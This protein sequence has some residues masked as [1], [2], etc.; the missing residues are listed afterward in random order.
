LDLVAAKLALA[1]NAT[2]SSIAGST[3]SRHVLPPGHLCQRQLQAGR[4]RP[5][6]Q[7]ARLADELRIELISSY[8]PQ[9]KGRIERLFGTL[10]DRMVKELRHGKVRT[11]GQ[12]D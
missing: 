12:A 9:V 2:S 7:I 6:S 1:V 10:Q 11:L 8:S 4:K 5:R 3:P